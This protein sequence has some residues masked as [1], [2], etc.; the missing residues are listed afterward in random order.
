M[1]SHFKSSELIFYL[2]IGSNVWLSSDLHPDHRMLYYYTTIAII[3][4]TSRLQTRD[5]KRWIIGVWLLLLKMHSKKQILKR[6]RSWIVLSSAFGCT[7]VFSRRT[8]FELIS[9][10]CPNSSLKVEFG[11]QSFQYSWV[12]RKGPSSGNGCLALD[13]EMRTLF[14]MLNV[15]RC[16]TWLPHS[17]IF[18]KGADETLLL[19]WNFH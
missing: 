2:S 16:W 12:H 3:P 15:K 17:S 19:H 10:C 8:I 5:K 1:K 13:S 18:L 4:R 9:L 11:L 14:W 6:T 7:L